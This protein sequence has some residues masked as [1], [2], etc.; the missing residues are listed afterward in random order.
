MELR[1]GKDYGCYDAVKKKAKPSNNEPICPTCRECT[2]QKKC[3]N[4][5]NLTTMNKCDICK[6]IAQTRTI[7]INFISILEKE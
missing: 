2:Y 5:R 4:R 3:L 1:E 7:V 6:K